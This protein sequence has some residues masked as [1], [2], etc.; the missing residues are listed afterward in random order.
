MEETDHILYVVATPIGNLEDITLRALNVLKK[1]D[2]I[3]CED[4]R[5]TLKL[6]THYDIKKHLVA[7]YRPIESKRVGAVISEIKK[8]QTAALVSDAGTPLVS[9]PG[10]MLVKQCINQGIQII[11]IPGVSA[12][13]TL[14]SVSH[15]AFN[16]YM[17]LG[18]PPEKRNQRV[19]WVKQLVSS[20]GLKLFYV[21]SHDIKKIV[22]L[23]LDTGI[24]PE[25][26]I[27]RELTKF[28]ESVFRGKLS[29]YDAKETKGEF[30][31]A[32][33]IENRI[34]QTDADADF[35]D[36]GLLEKR[37][38]F[39]IELGISRSRAIKIISKFFM[40]NKKDLYNRLV[41]LNLNNSTQ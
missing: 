36:M 20:S 24:D 31:V 8:N 32:V 35:I 41:E 17:F 29:L 12:V 34:N 4:T 13:T 6:L 22:A 21:S 9:D 30:T 1:V 27:G 5:R 37:F 10:G 39:L 19:E 3:I 15:I 18:F 38:L 11:P 25:V 7:F 33:N 23:I 28:Y 2:F 26:I 16:G 14:L 40:L